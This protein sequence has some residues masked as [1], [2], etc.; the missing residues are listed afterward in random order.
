MSIEDP[1]YLLISNLFTNDS[2]VSEHK[3]VRISFKHC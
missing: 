2:I 1:R 3:S